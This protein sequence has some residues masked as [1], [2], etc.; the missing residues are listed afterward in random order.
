MR[1]KV[2]ITGNSNYTMGDTDF[3]VFADATV[4][5]TLPPADTATGMIVFVKNTGTGTV[6]VAPANGDNIEGA[7]S[8]TLS[9]RYDGLQLISNGGHIWYVW[10]NSVGDEFTS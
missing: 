10:G 2:A 8:K 5:V 3:V 7:T 4:T 9:K 1:A 6:T